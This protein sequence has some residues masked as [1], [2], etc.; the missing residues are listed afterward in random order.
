MKIAIL[1][2]IALSIMGKVTEH[3]YAGTLKSRETKTTKV[4]VPAGQ[5]T[6]EVFN[7][8]DETR[9]NCSFIDTATNKVQLE[10]VNVGVCRW[11]FGTK[12]PVVINV[13]ATNLAPTGIEYQVIRT[14]L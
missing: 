4:D 5:T 7:P 10:Q 14:T 8:V 3:T 12:I 13:S 9:L 6:I 1:F 2:M 11:S